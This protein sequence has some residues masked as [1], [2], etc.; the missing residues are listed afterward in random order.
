MVRLW[1]SVP[2]CALAQYEGSITHQLSKGANRADQWQY[3]ERAEAY[4]AHLTQFIEA[5]L[6]KFVQVVH[7]GFGHWLT[8]TNI[9]AEGD[10]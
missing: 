5:S 8:L 6:F 10:A 3:K 4:H 7:N 9:G 2:A 1:N